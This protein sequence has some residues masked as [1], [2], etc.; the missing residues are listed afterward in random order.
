MPSTISHV[1]QIVAVSSAFVVNSEVQLPQISPFS[2][3]YNANGRFSDARFISLPF[4]ADIGSTLLRHRDESLVSVTVL[5]NPRLPTQL[6][7]SL[8]EISDSAVV[9]HIALSDADQDLSNLL[10][11]RSSVPFFVL[12][13]T[14]EDA[15]HNTL[16]LSK[17]SRVEKK[18]A[19]HVFYDKEAE[20]SPLTDDEVRSF[21]WSD[22]PK[23]NGVG[24]E[25]HSASHLYALYRSIASSAQ[26]LLKS[27]S[28]P[29]SRSGSDTSSTLVI[30]V[31]RPTFNLDI[32]SVA[33]VD[34]SLL[35][36]LPSLHDFFSPSIERILVVEQAW[37]WPTKW[38]PLYLDVLGA[39][40]QLP[41]PHP[42]VRSVTLGT[43]DAIT[44]ESICPSS[45][46][47]QHPLLQ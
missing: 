45:G 17:L 11:L 19:I 21:L 18:A 43:S 13:R 34:L 27:P 44:A 33:F 35:A 4:G 25:S 41:T 15:Y 6:L 22:I 37:N 29:L 47:R 9:I 24:A 20:F 23:V 26:S 28:G 10:L 16:L 38:S 8:P 5:S 46:N 2:R 30:T 3:I 31:A 32:K 36:P 12:S 14:P 7:H 1:A 42:S 40:Q 39:V